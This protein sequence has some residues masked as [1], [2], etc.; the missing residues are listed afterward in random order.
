[1]DSNTDSHYLLAA[2]GTD[3][4][5]AGSS[6]TREIEMSIKLITQDRVR[7]TAVYDPNSRCSTMPK[8]F[9]EH[10][11]CLHRMKSKT[12]THSFNSRPHQCVGIFEYFI[13]FVGIPGETYWV[14][15]CIVENAEHAMSPIYIGRETKPPLFPGGLSASESRQDYEKPMRPIL[16]GGVDKGR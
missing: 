8:E 1:M 10:I 5:E 12:A 16:A 15:F 7:F 14:P 13:R 6:Q 4:V 11:K 3:D 2:N 9:L